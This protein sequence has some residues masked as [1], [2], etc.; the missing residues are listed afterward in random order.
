MK[1]LGIESTAH[2][3]GA[4]MIDGT[5]IL[6]N[7][8]DM[9]SP[10][11]GGIHPREAANH[12][13]GVAGGVISQALVSKPDAIAYSCGPGIGPSL[14]IGMLIAR[15]LGIHYKIPIIPVNHGVAHLEIGLHSTKAK[16]PIAV[17]VSG[18]NTQ[19][20]G[21][22]NGW[23]IF[24]E[25]LDI[26]LGN[27][28]DKLARDLGIGHPGGPAI[29]ELAKKGKFTE[30]PYTVKG[31]DLNY[32]GIMTHARRL[33]KTR[34]PEDVA[35]SFQEHAFA[36]LVEVSERALAHTEKDEI[37]L[38]G[39][40]VKNQRLKKMYKT[41]CKERGA[42]LSVVPDELAGDNGAMVAWGGKV[43]FDKGFQIKPEETNY[44]Q[45]I[46]VDTDLAELFKP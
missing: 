20:I 28:L 5:R 1:I 37:L 43:L 30:M 27:A 10:K 26:A 16:D 22:D 36:M 25:T 15:Y 9:Y 32:S 31:M 8:W 33:L 42:K 12:H 39:G 29:E 4:G 44:F 40:V 46:R 19:I 24:G 35:Y 17:Y 14:R 2:T 7:V 11:K 3:F 41:M 38:V 13:V 23:K 34:S 6:S 45:R 18:G 21:M